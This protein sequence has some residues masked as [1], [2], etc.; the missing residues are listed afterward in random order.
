[1][2]EGIKTPVFW[3]IS[4]L[5]ILG[6]CGDLFVNNNYKTYVKKSINDDQYLTLMGSVGAIGNGCT[7][8]L[9]F[10]NLDFF[11]MYYFYFW[12]FGLL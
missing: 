10:T 1:M 11:G 5:V 7:R 8:Y 6:S 4:F 2:G 12:V 9:L 3:V